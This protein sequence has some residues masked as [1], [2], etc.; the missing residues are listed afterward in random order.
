MILVGARLLLLLCHNGGG[1]WYE[2]MDPNELNGLVPRDTSPEYR[3]GILSAF[4]GSLRL[5]R[6]QG[7]S[8]GRCGSRKHWVENRKLK[9]GGYCRESPKEGFKNPEEEPR[10]RKRGGPPPALAVGAAIAGAAAIGS[11]ITAAVILSAKGGKKEVDRAE[12]RA[13][14]ATAPI[15][16]ERVQEV[17]DES[18]RAKK[19]SEQEISRVKSEN[20]SLKQK[21]DEVTASLGKTGKEAEAAGAARQAAEEALLRSQEEATRHQE[22]VKT[23]EDEKSS[24]DAQVKGH[25]KQLKELDKKAKGKE[26]EISKLQ[27]E[28]ESQQKETERLRALGQEQ[29]QGKAAGDRTIR[30]RDNTILSLQKDLEGLSQER[31]KLASSLEGSQR[32]LGQTTTALDDARATLDIQSQAVQ[33]LIEVQRSLTQVIKRRGGVIAEQGKGNEELQANFISSQERLKEAEKSL[34]ETRKREDDLKLQVS[35]L[36][37]ESRDRAREVSGLRQQTD[38]LQ[39]NLNSISEERKSVEADLK[40]TRAALSKETGNRQAKEAELQAISDRLKELS[41]ESEQVGE[42]LAQTQRKLEESRSSQAA[43]EASLKESQSQMSGLSTAIGQER[44]EYASAQA[45]VQTLRQEVARTQAQRNAELER[46]GADVQAQV[47]AAVAAAEEAG[48]LRIRQIQERNDRAITEYQRQIQEIQSGVDDRVQSALAHQ[49]RESAVELME[50]REKAAKQVASLQQQLATKEDEVAAAED[51]PATFNTAGVQKKGRSL[52][53]NPDGSVNLTASVRRAGED[54][55]SGIP[56]KT[57]TAPGA[58]LDKLSSAAGSKIRA[59]GTELAAQE[60]GSALQSSTSL[61]ENE[62]V[63]AIEYATRQGVEVDSRELS[64][65]QER[66]TGFRQRIDHLVSQLDKTSNDVGHNPKQ[67]GEAVSLFWDEIRVATHQ[68]SRREEAFDLMASKIKA[69]YGRRNQETMNQFISEVSD[70]EPKDR[71]P[72]HPRVSSAAEQADR[73]FKAN[74][75]DMAREIEMARKVVMLDPEYDLKGPVDPSTG[76]LDLAAYRD[77]LGGMDIPVAA[78]RKG[79]GK[80]RVPSQRNKKTLP[81]S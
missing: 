5:D 11:G 57:L 80:K 74:Q 32:S 46:H 47:K 78:L 62:V 56:L 67:L 49:S 24:L 27:A 7:R 20:D 4:S 68:Q 9:K 43:T 34:G 58:R 54:R 50:L 12:R 17:Q 25:E 60:K 76:D 45:E 72:R 63:E 75:A 33:K 35:T 18:V 41:T 53:S 42:E 77:I 1:A 13:N 14:E 23:L 10:S 51:K 39:S 40:K 81:G 71:S 52:L 37:V 21:L 48:E 3:E 73:I 59:K 31:T 61:N 29:A 22:R 6:S 2:L 38:D 16:R 64:R 69:G 70:L 36:R 55:V 79:Q 19:E 66:S 8:L 28:V 30:D 65:L 15:T 26:A 44:A